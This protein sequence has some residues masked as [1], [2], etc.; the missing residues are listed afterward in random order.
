M[1]NIIGTPNDDFIFATSSDDTIRGVHGADTLF[2]GTDEEGGS[3]G[4]DLIYGNQGNDQLRG[5][6]G[7]DTAYGGQDEDF[8]V[9]ESGVDVL[10]G[11]LGA[12]EIHGEDGSD[13]LYG[14]QDNDFFLGGHEFDARGDLIYGNLGEDV[15]V[16]QSGND[17]LYGGQ[18]N[19]GLGGGSN[20]D[21]LYGN[22]G[23]DTLEGG[24]IFS[25]GGDDTLYGGQDNDLLL[26][27]GFDEEADSGDRDQLFGNLGNDTFDFSEDYDAQSSGTSDANSNRIMDFETGVDK[28]RAATNDDD[29]EYTEVAAPGITSVA[30]AIGFANSNNLFAPNTDYVFIAGAAHGYLMVNVNGDSNF[31]PNTDYTIVIEN[32]NTLAAFGFGDIINEFV[33]PPS[34]L[35]VAFT[36]Q[37]GNHTYDPDT[38]LLI[39]AL[40]DTNDD[41]IV[42]I[43]DTIN[44]G[45][46]PTTVDG[47]S[48]VRGNFTSADSLVT[49]VNTVVSSVIAV[50]TALGVVVWQESQI[51]EFDLFA[52]VVDANT[53]LLL[54]DI[55][56]ATPDQIVVTAI[57]SSPGQPDTSVSTI[58][59]Q[60]GDQGFLDLLF[61]F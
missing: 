26:G 42:S 11:N 25:G 56:D 28:V 22:L 35:A 17:T 51:P 27:G 39:A 14:G 34:L 32:S 33:P 46:Y 37:D 20:N 38:D 8:V 9:G 18:Q 50:Q 1:A 55:V 16:S 54:Q 47:S 21:V 3:S 2:G 12:D 23:R 36:D 15:L 57:S 29:P 43:G 48:S 59:P 7:D 30:G 60:L 10:Y 49:G 40:L 13:T 45:T 6:D 24:F 41:G 61:F 31:D 44:W 4:Q 53:T 19:D 52:T 58:T 5:G